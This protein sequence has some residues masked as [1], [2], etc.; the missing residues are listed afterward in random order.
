MNGCSL[1]IDTKA[2]LKRLEQIQAKTRASLQII[3]DTAVRAMESHAKSNAKWTDRTGNA[4]QRLKG[5]T[6]WEK[7]ALIA[8]ISHNVDYGM[9]LELC[10]EKKYAILEEALN[11]QAQNLLEAYQRFLNQL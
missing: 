3:A 5:S 7:D 9:W 10:H 2:V 11:S 8:A 1:S 6:R 4:R